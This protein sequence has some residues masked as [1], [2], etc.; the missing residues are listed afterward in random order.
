[1]QESKEHISQNCSLV[2]LC[3]KLNLQAK[4]HNHS[5]GGHRHFSEPEG[6]E[7]YSQ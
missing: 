4:C 2:A 1:M 6:K 7:I 3:C 5:L